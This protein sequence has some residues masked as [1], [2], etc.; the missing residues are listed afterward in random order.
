MPSAITA[1]T[2]DKLPDKNS[3]KPIISKLPMSTNLSG[4]APSGALPSTENMRFAIVAAEWNAHITDAL[5]DGALTLLKNNGV[6]DEDI[7]VY[8]V[9]GTVEL[10]FA[11]SQLIEASQ[12][13]AIIVFGCVIRGGTP[14][15]DY[16]CQ[17]VTQGIT[18]LN[19][20]CDT[21]VIFGVLTVDNE[22][23]ALDRAG[24]VLG[25]KGTEAA[26]AAIKMADFTRRVKDL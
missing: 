14:H 4:A 24:G 25:N 10:T 8:R 16:V 1:V 5:T 23:D 15:F 6:A 26:E 19:A 13:D 18:A 17:S 2:S 3:E 22:Q 7:D 20:D 21:P 12:Y 11:A 9:P